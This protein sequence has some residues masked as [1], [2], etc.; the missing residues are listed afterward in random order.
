MQ[1]RKEVG[2]LP[3][4]SFEDKLTSFDERLCLVEINGKFKKFQSLL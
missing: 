4:L 2:A 3:S 1:S